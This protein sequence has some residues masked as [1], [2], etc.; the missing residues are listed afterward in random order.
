MFPA[1][2]VHERSE[3]EC[4]HVVWGF[5]RVPVR[6][7]PPQC[8]CRRQRSRKTRA[9]L[10]PMAGRDTARAVAFFTTAPFAR[11]TLGDC[12]TMRLP[13]ASS[14]I[15]QALVPIAYI[16]CHSPGATV[17][18]RCDFRPSAGLL[19]YPIC[20]RSSRLLFGNRCDS[21]LCRCSDCRMPRAARCRSRGSPATREIRPKL[22][23]RRRAT[24]WSPGAAVINPGSRATIATR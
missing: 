13:S 23:H 15:I 5:F 9:R 1:R 22:R 18:T 4:R 17:R 7:M 8:S 2:I 14:T 20:R 10:Q 16:A 24:R 3:S 21:I 12:E 11:S 19:A 6:F